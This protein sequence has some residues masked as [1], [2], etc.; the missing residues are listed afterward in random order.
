[1]VNGKTVPGEHLAALRV[2]GPKPTIGA[3]VLV[4]LQY[5]S[6]IPL[7]YALTTR[8]LTTILDEEIIYQFTPVGPVLWLGIISLLAVLASWFPAR[9]ATRVSVRESLAYL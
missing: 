3:G 5:G 1:M 2:A 9:K 8:V 6:S 4:P 7:A